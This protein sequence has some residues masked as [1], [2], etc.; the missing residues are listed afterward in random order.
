MEEG[1]EDR[2]EEGKAGVL[3]FSSLPS[4]VSHHS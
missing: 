4:H 3:L 1:N 2:R